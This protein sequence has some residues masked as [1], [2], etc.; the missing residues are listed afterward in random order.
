MPILDQGFEKPSEIMRP[1][2]FHWNLQNPAYFA[3]E[4]T[5]NVKALIYVW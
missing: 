4:I 3:V 2:S 1:I 5:N